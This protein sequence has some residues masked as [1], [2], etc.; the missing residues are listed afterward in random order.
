MDRSDQVFQYPDIQ[1]TD[2]E[3]LPYMFEPQADEANGPPGSMSDDSSSGSDDYDSSGTESE[4]GDAD[5][6]P[7]RIGNTDW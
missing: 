1:Q 2:G 4:E 7:E 6:N 5:D 3:V